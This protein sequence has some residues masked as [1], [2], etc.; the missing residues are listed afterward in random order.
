MGQGYLSVMNSGLEA[1]SGG[2]ATTW[3]S[4]INGPTFSRFSHQHMQESTILGYQV[5]P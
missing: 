1:S 5:K 4:R 2:N 3:P